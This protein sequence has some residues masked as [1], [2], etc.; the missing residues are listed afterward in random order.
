MLAKSGDGREVLKLIDFGI[1]KVREDAGLGFTGIIASQTGFFVGTVEYAS[2][3][4]AMAMRGRELDG[5]T[6]LYSLG[7][8]LFEML[9]GAK[10]F[11]AD[12]PVALLLLR[13]MKDPVP[14]R[15]LRPDLEIP[16]IVSELVMK[17]L[18]REREARWGSAMEMQAAIGAVLDQRR[19]EPA[20]AP[21][22][23]E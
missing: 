3:E 23:L 19:A 20:K 2:P 6:D 5:R 1:A 12:S 7:L 13:L 16:Q 9:T 11:V 8:V 18:A 10:P 15:E 22:S 14:P 17:A 21:D 4:Q